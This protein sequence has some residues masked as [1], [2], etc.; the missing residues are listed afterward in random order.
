M[1]LQEAQRTIVSPKGIMRTQEQTSSTS[2]QAETSSGGLPSQVFQ[3]A[4]SLT[5]LNQIPGL[6]GC[7]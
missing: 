1:L 2:Q 5:L 6:D 3:G 4:F 7:E